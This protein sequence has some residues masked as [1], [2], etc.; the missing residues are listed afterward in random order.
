M[1]TPNFAVGHCLTPSPLISSNRTNRIQSEGGT[2][3][4]FHYSKGNIPGIKTQEIK[5]NIIIPAAVKTTQAQL[6]LIS[7]RK[8]KFNKGRILQVP[9]FGATAEKETKGGGRK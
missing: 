8:S 5:N 6:H 9:R 2:L 3:H 4:V 1:K 7:C